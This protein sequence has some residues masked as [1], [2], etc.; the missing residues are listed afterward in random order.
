MYRLVRRL[1]QAGITYAVVGG[2][3]VY[4]HGY[5]RTTQDVDL[6]LT[7]ED[8]AKFRSLFVPKA[9]EP[10]P[11]RRRRFMDRKNHIFVDILVTEHH[12]G[13]GEPT[14]ITFPNPIDVR[15]KIHSIYYI[16]LEA[17]LV[18]KLAARRFRDL[19]DVVNLIDPHNLDETF[20]KRLH[21]VLRAD[22][23]GCVEEKRREDQFNAMS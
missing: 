14:P 11:K 5:K 3:A 15:E 12:P 7:A 10:L 23:L 8:F 17:L 20:A 18:L 2:M 9:Y 4:A 21:P 6:L 22:Y 16:N 1:N 19:A 13:W